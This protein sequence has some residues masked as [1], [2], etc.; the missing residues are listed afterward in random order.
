MRYLCVEGQPNDKYP[1]LGVA[2][3]LHLF[4]P[5]SHI[6]LCCSNE[7]YDYVTGFYD[8]NLSINR[9]CSD[10]RLSPGSF[11]SNLI[12]CCS[13]IHSEGE[14]VMYISNSMILINSLKELVDKEY[15]SPVVC[16][17]RDVD[18]RLDDAKYPLGLVLFRNVP[19]CLTA[20]RDYCEKN[21]QVM[22]SCDEEHDA[23]LE[24]SVEG[25]SDADLN[26]LRVK[27]SHTIAPI[28]KI[29]QGLMSH[30]VGLENSPVTEFFEAE[31]YVDLSQFFA[32]E[33]SWKLGDFKVDEDRHI[34]K[35]N[36]KC[37]AA[38]VCIDPNSLPPTLRRPAMQCWNSVEAIACFNDPRLSIIHNI[39]N[40]L[41]GHR[42][43][44]SG[45]KP[46]LFGQWSRREVPSLEKEIVQV[47]F[48]SNY[49]NYN[50]HITNDY[51]RTA[52][53]M[54][55]DYKDTS[56]FKG[57]MFSGRKTVAMLLNYNNKVLSELGDRAIY[58]GL[59]TPYV[60]LL[61]RELRDLP[62]ERNGK[63]F[64]FTDDKLSVY[65]SEDA[66]VA[67]I[68]D[69][70]NY[71][72]SFITDSTPKSH[73]VDCLGL[74]VVPIIDEDCRLLEIEDVEPTSDACIQYFNA[75]LTA[76]ALGKRII[77][78]HMEYIQ[79]PHEPI[80]ST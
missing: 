3:S 62:Q 21:I 71:T 24:T 77:R 34:V 31:R 2:I 44:I 37:V 80:K 33:G 25:M 74:G 73:V 39:T 16:V 50:Q 18:L 32:A 4:M 59:Y 66:Y 23:L 12:A 35:N 72:H 17:K 13:E 67:Y 27:K 69:L 28:S 57:D 55:Y 1:I 52:F 58:C 7:T 36:I 64:A 30:V 19:E 49:L 9:V 79:P 41:C 38:T 70:K 29:V 43:V 46:G 8:F 26:E 75:N 47:L 48:K 40:R 54:L 65:E 14:D 22:S 42:F 11:I 68:K 76:E 78:A 51:Y 15:S 63:T 10:A 6:S 53:S 45:P 5:G 56:L 60:L 61:E 20:F